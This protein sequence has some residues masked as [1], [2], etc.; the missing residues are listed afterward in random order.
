MFAKNSFVNGF[1]IYIKGITIENVMHWITIRHV[2]KLFYT[3][4]VNINTYI[5]TCISFHCDDPEAQHNIS[6]IPEH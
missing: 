2:N 6:V 5:C 4:F 1:G 3:Y